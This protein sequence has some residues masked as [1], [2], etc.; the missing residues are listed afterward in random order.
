MTTVAH[1]V[2]HSSAPPTAPLPS[3]AQPLPAHAFGVGLDG[4]P[5]GDDGHQGKLA[6]TVHYAARMAAQLDRVLTLGALAHLTLRGGRTLD[7]AVRWGMGGECLV[8]GQVRSGHVHGLP[9]RPLPVQRSETPWSA[10]SRAARSSAHLDG[11][12][13]H[14]HTL[15]GAAWTVLFDDDLTALRLFGDLPPGPLA[16]TSSRVHGVLHGLSEPDVDLL[17]LTFALGTVVVVPLPEGIVAIAIPQRDPVA[18]EAVADE[19]R[20]VLTSEDS[21]QFWDSA[22]DAAVDPDLDVDADLDLDLH[23][24]DAARRE[25]DAYD[26][27][28]ADDRVVVPSGARFA[29]ML[30]ERAPRAARRARRRNR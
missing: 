12:L 18:A 27:L 4:R 7:V 28:F 29:G 23:I 8:D 22:P 15:H 10:A 2:A 20:T 5:R 13:R 11:A 16:V 24:G 6:A 30:D 3:R 19:I 25:G 1:P 9:R 14:V 17:C 21:G 26:R